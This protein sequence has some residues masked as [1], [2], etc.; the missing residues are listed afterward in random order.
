M[1]GKETVREGSEGDGRGGKLCL[2]R[3]EGV[4][5]REEDKEGRERGR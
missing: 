1:G 4:A 2:G 5:G 3:R